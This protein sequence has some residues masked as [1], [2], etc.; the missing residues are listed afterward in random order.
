M[1]EEGCLL[2]GSWEMERNRNGHPRPPSYHEAQSPT[3][4]QW[5]CHITVPFALLVPNLEQMNEE[6][7]SREVN[8]PELSNRYWWWLQPP[9]NGRR[10]RIVPTG[11][12]KKAV[13]TLAVGRLL[14]TNPT[15]LRFTP[16]LFSAKLGIW[17]EAELL[18]MQIINFL[19]AIWPSIKW[20]F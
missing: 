10:E 12:R 6:V 3:T 19:P 14:S 5:C 16:I 18:E 9:E 15:L 8:S 7:K 4:S 17:L 20:S 13:T 11:E 1:L 2:H